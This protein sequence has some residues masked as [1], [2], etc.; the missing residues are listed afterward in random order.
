MLEEVLGLQ[1]SATVCAVL[2]PWL[3]VEPVT[4]VP[5][6]FRET[7]ELVALLVTVIV[8]AALPAAFGANTICR[9][10]L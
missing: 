4:P 8:P 1:L 10:V 7:G 6:T 2:L 3:E 5:D 9:V